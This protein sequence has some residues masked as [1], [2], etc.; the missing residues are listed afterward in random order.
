MRADFWSTIRKMYAVGILVY[1]AA[2][3]VLALP[4]S[5]FS[6]WM[7]FMGRHAMYAL[8]WPVAAASQINAWRGQGGLQH[9]LR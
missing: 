9:W 3:C 2:T 6:D 1:F 7:S 4:I 8:A 5:D